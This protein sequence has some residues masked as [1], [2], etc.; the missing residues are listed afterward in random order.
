MG[1]EKAARGDHIPPVRA[2]HSEEDE[3]LQH[4]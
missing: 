3:L 4:R 2:A 1:Q